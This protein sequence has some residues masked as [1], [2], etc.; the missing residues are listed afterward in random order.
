MVRRRSCSIKTWDSIEV[1]KKGEPSG[2]I[3]T[4][5][6]LFTHKLDRFTLAWKPL[7]LLPYKDTDVPVEPF[8]E[9]TGYSREPS[10]PMVL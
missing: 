8:I 5:L 10:L 7:Y 6:P 1:T 3:A 2:V 9:L 4:Q